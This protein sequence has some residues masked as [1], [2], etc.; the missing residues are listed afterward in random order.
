MTKTLGEDRVLGY[1]NVIDN[2]GDVE[3]LSYVVWMDW[4][5]YLRGIRC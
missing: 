4:T 5:G 1:V 2:L 3:V